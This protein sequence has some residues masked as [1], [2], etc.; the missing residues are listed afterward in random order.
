[1]INT[2]DIYKKLKDGDSITK[3]IS[4]VHKEK[5]QNKSKQ[6]SIG[7][8]W[9]NT[10]L[11][12]DFPLLNETINQKRLDLLVDEVFQK[13]DTKL[14]TEILTKLQQEA[15]KLATILPSTFSID[16]LIIPKELEEKKENLKKIKTQVSFQEYEKEIQKVAD[17]FIAYIKNQGYSLDNLL[18]SGMKGSALTDWR[19]VMIAKGYLVDLEGDI[20]GPVEHGTGDGYTGEEYY[21]AAAEA[22]RGFYFKTE[23][24]RTPGYLA[25]KVVTATA[26][27]KAVKKDCKSK[28]Y[29]NIKI[30]KKNSNL[31][32]GRSHLKSGK[33][34]KIKNGDEL[35]G[36]I[37]KLRSPLYCKSKLGI[38]EICYGDLS[39]VLNCTN[40]GILAGG[41]INDVVV[42]N[43]MSFRHKTNQVDLIEVDFIKSLKK[44]KVKISELNL[45]LEIQKNKIIA[46]HDCQIELIKNEYNEISLMNLND[47]YI[48]PGLINISYGT[49]DEESFITLPFNF[50]VNLMKPKFIETTSKTIVLNYTKGDLIIEKKE[51]I[52]EED[53]ALVERLFEG[54]LKFIKEPE[55]LLDLI[56]DELPTI[57]LVHLELIIS[58]MF[59]DEL[60]L[61]VPCRLSSYKNPVIVGQK[62][63]PFKS[64]SWLNA[65]AF[66][67]INKAVETGLIGNKDAEMNPLEKIIMEE[68]QRSKG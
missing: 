61:T 46:K 7:R 27:L 14:S 51:Y 31:V 19:T 63:L 40:I 54:R 49:G 28:K 20:F 23:A 60:D 9:I 43:M 64:G 6:M 38:C 68:S 4:Y 13:Y 17:E 56:Y 50:K 44:S 42:N 55:L 33:L 65:L 26:N 58:N 34:V 57:D 47:K 62:Q 45:I 21:K 32:I 48:L 37:I 66:E 3:K 52:K 8:I 12:D 59:R 39:K 25:R 29:Y 67:N 16:S 30:T 41:A 35:I 5:T 2:K 24:V 1:M 11:P 18:N 10:I 36:K 53:P 22:R 15:F